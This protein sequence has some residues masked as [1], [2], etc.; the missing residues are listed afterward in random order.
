M[1]VFIIVC[2]A[3]VCMVA[4]VGVTCNAALTTLSQGQ[5]AQLERID[6]IGKATAWPRDGRPQ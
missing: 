2:I 6:Q 4:M 1:M 3:L 5:D